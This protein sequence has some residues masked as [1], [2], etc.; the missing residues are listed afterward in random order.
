[1]VRSTLVVQAAMIT[2]HPVSTN[3][4][5]VPFSPDVV[6]CAAGTDPR[7]WDAVMRELADRPLSSLQEIPSG[8]FTRVV[9]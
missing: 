7:V 9:A 5:A 2:T 3:P 6:R 8:A 1:M 4:A